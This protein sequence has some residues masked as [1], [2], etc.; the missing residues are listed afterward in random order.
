MEWIYK[1]YSHTFPNGASNG[2]KLK[3]NLGKQKQYTSG[4]SVHVPGL[5]RLEKK[6]GSL[7]REKT[8]PLTR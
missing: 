6:D 2:I 1:P 3:I 5:T 4:I 8:S 7:T